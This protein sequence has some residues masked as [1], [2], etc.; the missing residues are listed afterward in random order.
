MKNTNELSPWWARGITDSEGNFS[1][2][3]NSKSKKVTASYKVTQKNHS[4][5]ILT[6][7]KDFFGCGNIN[8]DNSKYGTYKF[9]VSDRS[10]L[11]NIIIPHF[12]NYPLVGSKHLDFLD[13]R[14][15]VLFPPEL[16]SEYLENIL[17]LKNKMNSSRP[18]E[19]RWNYLNE[20]TFNLEPA[21]IQAFVD[22]EGSFQCRIAEAKNYVCVNP[23]LEISQSSHDIEVLNAIKDYFGVGYLKP[24]YDIK[25]LSESIKSRSV[26]RLIINQFTT[27]IEFFDKYPLFTRKHLDYL[28]WKRIIEL[29][30]QNVHKTAEGKQHMIDIKQAMNQG[31]ILNTD[32]LDS[33]G[34]LNV[35][36]WF[37]SF[38]KKED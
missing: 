21:W 18:Y 7:L 13:F 29:K 20:C 35:I 38:N 8:I 22:G 2:N 4:L 17:I 9:I 24:K 25:S 5:I 16:R 27:V 3:Y 34:K 30:S 36:R 37:N 10:D 14:K 26:S 23:T 15:A 6:D 33:S 31:R 1:I 11:I 12:D 19:E 32:L 28:D